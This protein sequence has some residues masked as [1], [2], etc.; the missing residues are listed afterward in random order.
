MKFVRWEDGKAP[1]RTELR[2]VHAIDDGYGEQGWALVDLHFDANGDIVTN[3]KEVAGQCLSRGNDG[4]GYVLW[5]WDIGE[6][7][8][9]LKD[10]L[11]AMLKPTIEFGPD[12][13]TLEEK[14]PVFDGPRNDFVD[15]LGSL[16]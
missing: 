6:F 14:G 5:G 3:H 11:E 2:A 7:V 4:D 12:D 9:T 1:Y 16:P 8:G 10:A 13:Q 15:R